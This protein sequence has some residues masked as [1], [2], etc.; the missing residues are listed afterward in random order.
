MVR[1]FLAGAAL[2]TPPP[3]G[4]LPF[5]KGEEWTLRV[6]PCKMVGLFY[7]MLGMSCRMQEAFDKM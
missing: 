6:E 2:L 4:H 3:Y 1:L 7:E 5:Q